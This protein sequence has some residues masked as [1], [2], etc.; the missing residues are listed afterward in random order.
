VGFRFSFE[1]RL[2][3]PDWVVIDHHPNELKPRQ[4]QLIHDPDK[5]AGS[6]C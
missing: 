4:A 1:A 3:Q 2:D 6:L 5:S